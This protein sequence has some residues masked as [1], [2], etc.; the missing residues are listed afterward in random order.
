M[1]VKHNCMK[2][3]AKLKIKQS[4]LTGVAGAVVGCFAGVTG[5][6]VGDFVVGD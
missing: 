2:V 1:S 3:F 6:L 4:I 5:D